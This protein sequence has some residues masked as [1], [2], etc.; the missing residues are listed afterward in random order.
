MMHKTTLITTALIWYAIIAV[1][2]FG[3]AASGAAV[4]E[5]AE[6]NECN[7]DPRYTMCFRNDAAP[8]AK[9]I[10]AAAIWPLYWSWEVF[11]RA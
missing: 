11:D 9:G 1:I 10:A 3:H 5:D 2:T 6:Y 7:N 4:R 8:V